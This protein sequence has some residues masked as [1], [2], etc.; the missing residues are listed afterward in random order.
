PKCLVLSD[1]R[2]RLLLSQRD[3]PISFT[4]LAN[5]E[6]LSFSFTHWTIPHLFL[7][8]RNHLSLSPSSV[9]PFTPSLPSPAPLSSFTCHLSCTIFLGAL[10]LSHR[11]PGHALPVLLSKKNEKRNH[12]PV[13]YATVM[14]SP[15]KGDHSVGLGRSAIDG[16]EG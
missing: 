11:I 5:K 3:L 13:S 12:S 14:Q 16:R 4:P 2:A 10:L 7:F 9:S 6:T 8:I 15:T 1:P